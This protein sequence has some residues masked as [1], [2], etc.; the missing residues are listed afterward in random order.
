MKRST[1][2]IHPGLTALSILLG[3]LIA[4]GGIGTLFF[5]FR[6]ETLQDEL[7]LKSAE[8]D[9]EKLSKL[10]ETLKRDKLISDVIAP[11][12]NVPVLSFPQNE[13]NLV[14]SFV[15]LE[16]EH[17]RGEANLNYVV[18]VRK[19]PQLQQNGAIK[20]TDVDEDEDEVEDHYFEASN[21]AMKSSRFPLGLTRS[22]KIVNGAYLWRVLPGHLEVI[23]G[24]S[25]PI[26]N[27]EW[28][29]FS[30][31][32]IYPD[33]IDRIISACSILVGVNYNQHSV[34]LKRD[35]KGK[36]AG[37]EW[38]LVNR[39]AERM[40]AGPEIATRCKYSE[41]FPV[42]MRRMIYCSMD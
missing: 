33:A 25:R 23:D 13:S 34:F 37:F 7:R 35:E 18:H 40:L 20:K 16:W 39:L 6:I 28:S 31:F 42:H 41:L 22:R 27:G 2:L 9:A 36:T 15:I 24:K 26:K 30:K 38:E 17:R 12:S 21:P 3:V 14:G 4:A 10:Q 1:I 32:T 29:Q 19:L 11:L 5:N 8:L